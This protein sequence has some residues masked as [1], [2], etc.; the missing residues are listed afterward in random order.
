MHATSNNLGE[1]LTAG[2]QIV[3]T[4]LD[5][6]WTIRMVD[7]EKQ[8]LSIK[9]FTFRVHL[10][11]FSVTDFYKIALSLPSP[12]SPSHHTVPTRDGRT[13]ESLEN[14]RQFILSA[15][16]ITVYS[17]STYLSNN[18]VH[19]QLSHVHACTYWISLANVATPSILKFPSA[20]SP[21]CEIKNT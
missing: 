6:M 4:S 1:Q 14:R 10:D 11:V 13:I 17:E 19:P 18:S 15:A 16:V 5:T 20:I 7:H 2:E 12:D 21:L 9:L 3:H 8:L